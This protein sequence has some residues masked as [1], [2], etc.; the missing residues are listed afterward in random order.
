M[1][2][3]DFIKRRFRRY[4]IDFPLFASECLKIRTK[5]GAI[6]PFLLNS[7]Q[8][9]FWERFR[10]QLSSKGHCRFVVL[11]ARQMG[12]STLIEAIYFWRTLFNV[13]FKTLVLTHLD[14]ETQELFEMKRRYF[15]YLPPVFD[16]STRASNTTELSFK[17]PLDSAIKTATAGSKNVGHGSTFQQVHWSEVARS[18]NQGDM[19]AGVIQTVPSGL[20]IAGTSIVY[21]STANGTGEHFSDV[22][23]DAVKCLNEYEPVFYPWFAMQEYRIQDEEKIELTNYEQSI[24][25]EFE[26]DDAQ[27]KWRRIKIASFD[28]TQELKNRFFREQY[29]ATAE[30]A[31]DTSDDSLILA[32]DVRAARSRSVA[33]SD[34]EN[35]AVILGIDP[36]Y[37][38]KDSTAFALRQGRKLK[39]VVTRKGWTPIQTVDFALQ[40]IENND[41][42]HI[43][44]DDTGGYG[45]GIIDMLKQAGQEAIVTGVVANS[46]AT[47][48]G[49]YHDKR[50]EM[51]GR[52]AEWVLNADIL[53]SEAIQA[54]LTM[55][56][57]GHDNKDRLQLESKRKLNRSPDIGDAIALTFAFKISGKQNAREYEADKKDESRNRRRTI[58]SSGYGGRV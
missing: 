48:T 34:V 7:V 35:S 2:N 46:N 27:L 4:S 44:I 42:D 26:L 20:E 31:F 23:F 45:S 18:R 54:D 16:V 37:R 21:E 12:L 13:G 40:L 28:G 11:K 6:K 17:S 22:W 33:D 19:V 52:M 39:R 25:S 36:A 9:D 43:F 10:A 51:W 8:R 49:T 47:N 50:A 41:V 3:E 56:K 53:D 55:L 58:I 57:M 29:P 30:E 24:K 5:S 1:E 32:R 38:G 14:T 15:E